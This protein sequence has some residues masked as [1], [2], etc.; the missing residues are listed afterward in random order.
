MFPMFL[1]ELEGEVLEKIALSLLIA[2]YLQR[3]FQI[4]PS[5]SI[6]VNC[7]TPSRFVSDFQFYLFR[8]TQGR[9]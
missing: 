3:D 9:A 6:G 5:A 1:R 7:G 8:G 2:R 4:L